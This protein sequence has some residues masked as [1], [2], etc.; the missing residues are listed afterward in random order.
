MG[1]QQ[2]KAV[3]A[4][5][6]KSVVFALLLAGWV[7]RL[8]SAGQLSETDEFA[9]VGTAVA[10][11]ANRFEPVRV[12][13]VLDLDNTL[14]AMDSPLGSDQWFEW[15]KYLLEHEPQ[16]E[17]LVA[18]SF[19]GLLAAQGLLYNLQPMHP[20][21]ENLPRLLRR[22]QQLGVRTVV[23]TSRGPE[24]RDATERELKRNGYDLAKSAIEVKRLPRGEFLPFHPDRP[25]EDG[26]TQEEIAKYDLSDPR[27]ISFEDG[28]MMTAGQHKGAMLLTLLHDAEHDI[29][30][31][32]YDDDNIRH[33]ANVYAA[34]LARDKEI[35]AFHYTREEANV[36]QFQYGSKKDVTKRWKKL[37]RVLEEVLAP[38]E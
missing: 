37:Y 12:L 2:L 10:Q 33:V 6:W 32:V 28:I 23:L 21:Q 31:V 18:K 11:Y 20:P 27:P 25:H 30:A 9:E 26:L 1:R 22:V 5:G 29:D 16:S 34:V 38:R 7:G 36:K 14:L 13:L 35:S 3:V 17:L 19:A 15:Q 24:F 4:A 8:A